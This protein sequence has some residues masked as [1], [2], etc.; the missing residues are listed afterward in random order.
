[1]EMSNYINPQ[2]L[3]WARE[4]VNL[5]V[6][7]LAIKMRKS[8]EEILLWESGDKVPAYGSLESLAKHFGIPIKGSAQ[9]NLFE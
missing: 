7:D 4:R 2:I 9:G 8:T 5:S 6:E 3:V 1:M